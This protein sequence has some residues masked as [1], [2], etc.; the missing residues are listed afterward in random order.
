MDWEKVFSL[1]GVEEEDTTEGLEDFRN[2]PFFKI[3]MFMKLIQN[4]M[5]FKKQVLSFFKKSNKE[6]NEADIDK[7]GDYMM[8]VR[9]FYWVEQL[10]L[11]KLTELDL[12][13]INISDLMM[14]I[15]YSISYFEGNEEY[16]KCAVLKKFQDHMQKIKKPLD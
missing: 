15:D 3:R 8:F 4:G 9:A 14:C 6:L 2:T 10:E 13:Y 7:A 12:K 11:N 5:N 1:F 16:E